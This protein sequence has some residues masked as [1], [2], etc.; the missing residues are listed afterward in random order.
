MT[1]ACL[2]LRSPASSPFPSAAGVGSCVRWAQPLPPKLFR[3]AL[4]P[5]AMPAVPRRLLLPAAAGI[6][7]FLSGGASGAA[8]A[9]LAVRRGMQLFKQGD[10]AGSVAEFDRAIELDPRQKAYLWQRGLSLYYLDRFEEGAEQFRLDVAANPNDTEESIWCFL[11]EAQLYGVEEARKRFLEVGLDG[12]PVMRA[13]YAMFKDG[14]DPE[15]LASNFS[16]SSDGELFYASLYAGLY[17]ESQKNADSAKSHIVAACKSRYGSRSG[18]YMASLALVH[19][20]CRNWTLE[21]QES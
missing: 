8:A 5:A 16:S 9:S 7:D 20:Q 11:C 15:K 13:A 14:G 18:D 10:V 19:C 21:G 2:S 6:W 17:H 12:R 4:P 1:S 3:S